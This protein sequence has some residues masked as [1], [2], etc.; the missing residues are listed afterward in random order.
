MIFQKLRKKNKNLSTVPLV[1]SYHPALDGLGDIIKSLLPIL[2][3]SNE[4]RRIF[5][6][7]PLFAYKRVRNLKN[8]SVRSKVKRDNSIFSNNNTRIVII[9][10][11]VIMWKRVV[12]FKEKTGMSLIATHV[13]LFASLSARSA[14]KGT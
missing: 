9:Y 6:E 3:A 5:P 2:H 12:D 10:R 4:M 13:V 1:V 7:L 14:V 11:F 8:D